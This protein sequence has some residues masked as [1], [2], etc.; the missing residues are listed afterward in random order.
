MHD[1]DPWIRQQRQEAIELPLAL[2]KFVYFPTFLTPETASSIFQ[3]L[4][5][6]TPW[7]ADKV[8]VFGKWHDQ[9]RLTAWY[10]TEKRTYAY[11]G[12]ELDSIKMSPILIDL[13]NAIEE[14][15]ETRFNSVLLNLYR[16]GTDSNGWH[17]DDEEELGPDPSIA[18]L[19]LGATRVFQL[20]HKKETYKLSLQPGSL[21]L[22]GDGSQIYW[23]HQLP[24]TKKAIGPRV[25]C[26]FRKI[27]D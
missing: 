4:Y 20:K 25:N 5:T 7:R 27:L 8:R 13:K 1:L 11:S 22:M 21:I 23:K 26:T 24:K 17:S 14:K 2:A 18:S 19:S 12:L 16:D 3:A 15:V 6:E 9:P 10:A